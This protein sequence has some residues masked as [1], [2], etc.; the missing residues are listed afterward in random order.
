M[1]WTS[2]FNLDIWTKS[3][4]NKIASLFKIGMPKI[5]K[6]LVLYHHYII[7][8]PP[9]DLKNVT[10]EKI[11]DVHRRI[12]ASGTFNFMKSQIQISS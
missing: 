9:I 6:N 10:K 7:L 5:Q 1:I 2:D 8:L 3:R 4:L 11:F 12:K